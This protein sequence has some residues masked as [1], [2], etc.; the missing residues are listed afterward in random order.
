KKVWN[1]DSKRSSSSNDARDKS[2]LARS[3]SH[4]SGKD[5]KQY[6]AIASAL[7]VVST[8][9]DRNERTTRAA[10]SSVRMPSSTESKMRI[11]SPVDH[12]FL[13]WQASQTQA[14]TSS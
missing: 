9:A 2:G 10:S 11:P 5:A 1:G 4:W 14:E 8:P 3:T 12:R 13:R 6:T 7:A